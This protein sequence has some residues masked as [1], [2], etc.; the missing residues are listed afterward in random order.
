ML[1]LCALGTEA[2]K[3]KKYEQGQGQG[4]GTS[5]GYGAGSGSGIDGSSKTHTPGTVS[6]S[7]L[8]QQVLIMISPTF[9]SCDSAGGSL[10]ALLSTNTS[11]RHMLQAAHATC[12][13]AA[14][15][16]IIHASVAVAML[17][18]CLLEML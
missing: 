9:W 11:T 18:S 16:C 1:V 7:Q 15:V 14:E 3:E 8:Q 12:Q 6:A 17:L 2:N 10:C 13:L 5:S 4:Y